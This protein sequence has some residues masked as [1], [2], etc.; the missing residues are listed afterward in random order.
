MGVLRIPA[1][2]SDLLHVSL[3]YFT[4]ARYVCS[5]SFKLNLF[6]L[7]CTAEFVNKNRLSSRETRSSS[8][9]MLTNKNHV[10]GDSRVYISADLYTNIR[11]KNVEKYVH[12]TCYV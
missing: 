5:F 12:K 9:Q 8:S 10:N 1:G 11:H 2:C 3:K 4:R 6:R 7:N